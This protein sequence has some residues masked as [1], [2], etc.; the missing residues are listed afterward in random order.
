[1]CLINGFWCKGHCVSHTQ[2][3]I[4]C[5]IMSR[6]VPIRILEYIFLFLPQILFHFCFIP[7]SYVCLSIL[8]IQSD[9]IFMIYSFDPKAHL[10]ASF[11][12][13]TKKK[14]KKK[15]R[16][17]FASSTDS[18]VVVL[19]QRVVSCP[20]APICRCLWAARAFWR[21]SCRDVTGAVRFMN[22]LSRMNGRNSELFCPNPRRV[23][24]K[25]ILAIVT[26]YQVQG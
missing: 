12:F 7:S 24:I 14:K 20:S 17:G 21:P 1:M 18:R 11:S 5:P 10:S 25:Y 15:N 8:L 23:I 19:F 6:S 26:N 3:I 22:E 16:K 13:N 4:P 9:A 2:K